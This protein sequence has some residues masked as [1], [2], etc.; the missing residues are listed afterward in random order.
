MKLILQI[1]FGIVIGGVLFTYI[2]PLLPPLNIPELA[3][4]DR[5]D[6]STLTLRRIVELQ[7][8]QLAELHA[9][10]E[11]AE[12]TRQITLAQLM[13]IAATVNEKLQHGVESVPQ[14]AVENTAAEIETGLLNEEEQRKEIAWKE[15]YIAP[16]TCQNI[17]SQEAVVECGNFHIR[18]RREFESLWEQGLIR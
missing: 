7:E 10:L 16:E 2:E 8:K 4:N 13:Q 1:I 11:H 15:F 14:T 17:D 12:H 18:K 6:E 5:E 9:Q 3:G